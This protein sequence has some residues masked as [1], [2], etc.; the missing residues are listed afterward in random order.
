MIGQ[1][2][3]LAGDSDALPPRIHK[4]LHQAKFEG[5]A[6]VIERKQTTTK[7][8]AS[9]SRDLAWGELDGISDEVGNDLA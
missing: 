4:P 2:S 1:L 5:N 3:P 8:N 6:L 9:L 7:G